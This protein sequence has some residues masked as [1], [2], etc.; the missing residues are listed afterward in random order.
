[1]FIRQGESGSSILEK[2]FSFGFNDFTCCAVQNDT[3][4]FAHPCVWI[5]GGEG[6]FSQLRF[7]LDP[8]DGE[9]EHDAA[10]RGYKAMTQ[11]MSAQD[12]A[13]EE[14]SAVSP[15]AAGNDN[16][17]GALADVSSVDELENKGWVT[18]SNVESID[19]DSF[20]TKEARLRLQ[21]MLPENAEVA[22]ARMDMEG[23]G[24]EPV[25]AD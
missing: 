24:I 21:T 6:V 15:L 14:D 12:L 9:S 2:S 25:R 20:F 4:E 13:M 18:A 3:S 23:M 5:M 7:V 1:M 8:I 17:F 16:P 10:E 19:P 22:L 11:A